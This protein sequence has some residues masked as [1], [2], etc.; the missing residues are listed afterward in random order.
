MELLSTPRQEAVPQLRA[1][2]L[3]CLRQDTVTGFDL[4]IYWRR[5]DAPVLYRGSHIPITRDTLTQLLESGRNEIW[6]PTSQESEYRQYLE[7]NLDAILTEETIPIVEKSKV[8]YDSA[9]GLMQEIFENPRST[10]MVKRCRALASRTSAFLMR[11]RSAFGHLLSLASYD[12]QTYTHSVNVYVFAFMLAQYVGFRDPQ[13]L[14]EF[15][16]GLL[17]HD[18]GK[19]VLDPAIVRC[20]G[21]LTNEQWRQ[22]RRHPE[23]GYAI[24]KEHG[25]FSPLTLSIVRHHHEKLTGNGYPDGLR[26]DEIPPLVRISTIADI[27]DAL[28]T[29]RPYKDALGSFPALKTMQEMM[30]H[31]LDMDFFRQFVELMG[32]PNQE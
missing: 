13:Q 10:E 29:N 22:M 6:V 8:L 27:F 12:Y 16:E 24:L 25:K 23:F 19:S 20:R 17:L 14:Q 4:Y 2:P 32:N 9:S 3:A 28:T 30:S 5:S 11:E 21:A 1:I 15:G 18:I 26:G 7:Q 31:D